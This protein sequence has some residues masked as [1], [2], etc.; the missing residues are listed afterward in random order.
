MGGGGGDH[1][2]RGRNIQ[3]LPGKEV[4]FFRG[5]L[6]AIL[7]PYIGFLFL[8]VS[9]RMLMYYKK[10]IMRLGVTVR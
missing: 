5:A 10:C 9:C 7:C 6:P 8:G 3:N 1:S 2:I 4:E